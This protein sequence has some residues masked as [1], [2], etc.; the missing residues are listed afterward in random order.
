MRRA[1]QRT[2]IQKIPRF[3][4][5]VFYNFMKRKIIFHFILIVIAGFFVIISSN[6]ESVTITKKEDLT[7]IACGWP[8]DFFTEDES[9]RDPPYPWEMHCVLVPVSMLDTFVRSYSWSNFLLNIL[10][11]YILIALMYSFV[12]AVLIRLAKKWRQ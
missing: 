3:S 7:S 12:H 8:L 5:G 11:F 2:N 10:F 1:A 4:S 9:W 6:I